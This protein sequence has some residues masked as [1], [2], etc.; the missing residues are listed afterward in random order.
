VAVW[1]VSRLPERDQ[2][3][4]WHEVICQ[5]FVPLT[6]SRKERGAGFASTVETR[7]LARNNRARTSSKAATSACVAGSCRS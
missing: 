7:L 6:P 3:D 2:F 1:D 4:Y 5:A